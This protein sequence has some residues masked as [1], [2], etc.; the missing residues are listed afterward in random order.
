[1]PN[2]FISNGELRNLLAKATIDE[3]LAL[4]KILNPALTEP[5]TSDNLQKEICMC[6]G[7]GLANFLGVAVLVT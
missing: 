4:T 7:H 3:R 2:N 6:G 5:F 1:M